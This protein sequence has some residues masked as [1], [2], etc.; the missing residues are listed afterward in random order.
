MDGPLDSET[1][2]GN[3]KPRLTGENPVFLIS[4]PHA[5]AIWEAAGLFGMRKGEDPAGFTCR[6]LLFTNECRTPSA[7]PGL[8]NKAGASDTVA[9][10]KTQDR[11]PSPRGRGGRSPLRHYS[12]DRVP[13]HRVSPPPPTQACQATY[14]PP[15]P[16][17]GPLPGTHAHSCV[18]AGVSGRLGAAVALTAPTAGPAVGLF[19]RACL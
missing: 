19:P 18:P 9:S 17:P 3:W 7:R 16:R 4:S 15:T 13:R 14:G 12:E 11:R 10:W 6:R 8:L 1:S 5:G 2:P